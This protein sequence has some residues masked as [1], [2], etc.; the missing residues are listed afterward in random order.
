MAEEGGPPPLK[1]I[2]VAPTFYTSLDDLRYK[3][4]LESCRQAAKHGIRLI[5]VDAS[6]LEEVR[7]GLENAG[8]DDKGRGFVKVILQISKGKKG[9]AL[10]EVI[11]EACTEMQ[12]GIIAFQE[13]E[14][15]DM[16][17]HWHPLV[18]HMMATESDVTVLRRAA[19]LFQST[20]PIEQYHCETFANMYLDSLGASIG[21]ASV[22][23][24]MGPVAFTT[25]Y[26]NYWLEYQG[27]LWDVQLVPLIHAH[28]QG[29]KVS[30][31][32][33]EYHHPETMKEQEQGV[34]LWNEKR[35]FQLNFLKDTVG[36]EMKD[37]SPS[38]AK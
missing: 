33:V 10:R 25:K 8:K 6:P 38:A 24:T 30:S 7:T 23:W 26:A 18:R 20:Y 12:N 4:G 9:S 32:E 27:E 29:A 34:A 31:F 16:F 11:Q 2:V 19:A 22:D 3:L 21:L 15:V 35:L 1:L 36:K 14:K 28:L 17:R 13:L 37:N 5:L